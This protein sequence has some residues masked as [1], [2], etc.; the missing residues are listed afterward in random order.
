M[1]DEELVEKEVERLM[2]VLVPALCER[3]GFSR[4]QVEAFL[5]AQEDFWD[6]Q[7]HVVGRMFVLGFELGEGDEE[8]DG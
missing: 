5:Q 7:K 4:R 2:A 6:E 3:T 1:S 8:I